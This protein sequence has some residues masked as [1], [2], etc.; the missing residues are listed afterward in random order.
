MTGQ[1]WR[2]QC[3]TLNDGPLD[4]PAWC[5]GCRFEIKEDRSAEI[6]AVYELVPVGRTVVPCQHCGARLVGVVCADCG[7][8]ATSTNGHR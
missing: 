6:E 2:H 5:S 4:F 7:T 3:G 1:A 8:P